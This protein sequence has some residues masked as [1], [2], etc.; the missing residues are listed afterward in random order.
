MTP[1]N[2]WS[3]IN[4]DEKNEANAALVATMKAAASCTRCK[5]ELPPGFINAGE[6]QEC[7]SCKSKI[8]VEVFPALFRPLERGRSGEALI[9]ESDASCFYH[10][11]KQAAVVCGACGRF[12]CSLCDVDVEGQH[13][14]PPCL[15]AHH[16]QGK[17]KSLESRRILNDTVALHLALVSILIFYISFITAPLALYWAIKHRNSPSSILRRSRF[18]WVFAVILSSI[19]ILAWIALVIVVLVANPFKRA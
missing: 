15:E 19:I 11:Q 18:R 12:V 10:P 14:C 4:W 7:S 17:I 1:S 8:K 3:F 13:L 9:I 6:F 16:K 5:A 2:E